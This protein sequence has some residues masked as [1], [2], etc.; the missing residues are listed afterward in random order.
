MKEK[1]VF[2]DW[3]EVSPGYGK[4]L[5]YEFPVDAS[6]YGIR[7]RK[8]NPVVDEKPCIVCDKPWESYDCGA[9]TSVAKIDGKY[10]LWYEPI[11]GTDIYDDFHAR[12]CLALSDDGINWE[13]PVIGVYE[14]E[15]TKENNVVRPDPVLC[16]HGTVVMYDKNAPKEE[17]YKQV[18]TRI[19]GS[20][21]YNKF[22]IGMT[23]PDG[24]NWT[25]TGV[26]S[27]E[28]ADTQSTLMYDT[29]INKYVVYSKDRF[30]P[31]GDRRAI[32]RAVSN[33]F[34]TFTDCGVVVDPSMPTNSPDTDLYTSA[35]IQWP[36]ARDAYVMFPSKYNRTTD[37]INSHMA[38]SRDGI[39]W[40]FPDNEPS[41]DNRPGMNTMYMGVG[42]VDNEDG[43]WSHYFAA[44]SHSHNTA[45]AIDA[46]AGA[47]HRATFREDGYMSVRA[48]SYG[49]FA[50]SRVFKLNDADIM[51]NGECEMG[52]YIKLEIVERGWS[53]P[54]KG[55]SK[56]DCRLEKADGVWQ[57]VSWAKPLSELDPDT[58]YRIKVYM[59][60]SD[61][62]AIKL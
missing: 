42:V 62:Y 26:V 57:R 49:G 1:I 30:T 15:G 22:L 31:T 8:H 16:D 52:G 12:L 20:G 36:G 61:L 33:D 53:T 60:A 21:K 6:P 4:H 25:E 50:T 10:H 9:Y 38:T 45:L 39:K 7:L 29:N 32:M 40:C 59:Y 13:K 2:P 51:I 47:I 23:S 18:F 3:R 46:H 19:G 58:E 48:D 54:I 34:K 37:K 28:G 14:A 43:T 35:V 27:Y 55:F 17:R 44:F 24:I 56:D 41:I 5:R 11:S